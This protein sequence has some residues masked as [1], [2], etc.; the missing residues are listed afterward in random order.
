MQDI[1]EL[2]RLAKAAPD[3]PCEGADA[4]AHRHL[5]GVRERLAQLRSLEAELERMTEGRVAECRVIEVLADALRGHCA[6]PTHGRPAQT[7]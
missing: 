1:R 3:A 4:I 2:L 7:R 6:D 5:A